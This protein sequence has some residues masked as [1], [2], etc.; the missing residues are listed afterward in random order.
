ME[1]SMGGGRKERAWSM[2]QGAR[3]TEHGAR[4]MEKRSSGQQIESRCRLSQGWY[5]VSGICPGNHSSISPSARQQSREGAN[6][7]DQ[8]PP[9]R[10]WVSNRMERAW[11][12]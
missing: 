12:P 7:R 2:E 5:S 10:P 1:G 4:K 8:S 3:S 11:R 9:C 6:F